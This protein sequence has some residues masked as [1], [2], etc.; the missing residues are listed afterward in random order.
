MNLR[1]S[2]FKNTTSFFQPLNLHSNSICNRNSIF[3]WNNETL[4]NALCGKIRFSYTNRMDTEKG[5]STNHNNMILT[6]AQPDVYWAAVTRATTD[7]APLPQLVIALYQNRT[8]TFWTCLVY[9]I[10][11]AWLLNFHCI[12]QMDLF[13][14]KFKHYQFY[15]TRDC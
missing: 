4:P 5:S 8:L 11:T 3:V 2:W 9:T 1:L 14:Y 12:L 6:L 7:T 13:E 15:H 10:Y